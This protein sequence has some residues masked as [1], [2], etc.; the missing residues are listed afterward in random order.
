MRMKMYI[1]WFVLGTEAGGDFR[2]GRVGDGEC[3]R[4][5]RERDGESCDA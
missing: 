4:L 3:P 5:I 2:R 1:L